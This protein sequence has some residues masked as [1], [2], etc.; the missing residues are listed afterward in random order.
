MVLMGKKIYDFTNPKGEIVKGMR[1]IVAEE[2]PPDKGEGYECDSYFF[3]AD[4][5]LYTEL[6]MI[7]AG[8]SVEITYNKYGKIS[9]IIRKEG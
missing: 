3:S 2:I 1:I 4:S 8:A 9:K 6:I 7:P 5:L